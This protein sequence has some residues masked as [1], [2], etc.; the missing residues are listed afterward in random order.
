MNRKPLLIGAVSLLVLLLLGLGAIGLATQASNRRPA[1]GAKAPDFSL[2]LYE[3]YRAGLPVTTKLS[4][5]QGKVV[6]VNFWASWCIPCK[7][8]APALQAV[9]DKYSDRNVVVLGVNYLDTEREAL[10]FLGTYGVTYANG[11]D[12]KQQIAHQ[13]RITGVPETFIVDK[14]GVLREVY[15]Q[16]VTERQLSDVL[17]RLLAEP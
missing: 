12:L 13:Y 16:P 5:L 10:G 7:D 14:K 2:S 11:I 9:S 8:E 15:I 3:N 6:L 1:T 17:D 4:E